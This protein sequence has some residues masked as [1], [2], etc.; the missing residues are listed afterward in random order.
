MRGGGSGDAAGIWGAA[1]GEAVAVSGEEAVEDAG[2]GE[3]AGDLQEKAHHDGEEGWRES[4]PDLDKGADFCVE[5]AF[6]RA[7]VHDL[8]DAGG[9][10]TIGGGIEVRGG[11]VDPINAMMNVFFAIVGDFA[12]AKGADAIVKNLEGGLGGGGHVAPIACVIMVGAGK[13]KINAFR[14]RR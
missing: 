4:F 5:G 14:F 2:E 9:V 10:E 13:R 1:A 8:G 6:G 3:H 12:A 11:D 7:G